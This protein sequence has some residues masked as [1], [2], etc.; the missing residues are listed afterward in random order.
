MTASNRKPQ[1]LQEKFGFH[2]DDLKTPQHDAIMMWL[3]TSIRQDAAEVF[4]FG[5]SWSETAGKRIVASF[6]E[7]REYCKTK[8]YTQHTLEIPTL[9]ERTPPEILGC[10]W[11]HPIQNHQSKWISGFIDL[12]VDIRVP[13]LQVDETRWYQGFTVQRFL[14]QRIY[15]IEAKPKITSIGET[16]RQIRFYQQHDGDGS[17][18]YVATP[19]SRFAQIF[20]DQGIGF[21]EVPKHVIG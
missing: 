19:D 10:T 4:G 21:I 16:I 15:L 17:C 14:A 12:R 3:D 9:P 18:F 1:T 13:T 6:E 5:K 20:R 7:Y 8:N 11:E 2:D